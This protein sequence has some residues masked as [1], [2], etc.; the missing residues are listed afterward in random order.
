[1]PKENRERKVRQ[2][3]RPKKSDVFQDIL[4]VG[5]R[6]SW[7]QMPWGTPVILLYFHSWSRLVHSTHVAPVLQ[8]SVTGRLCSTRS[9]GM[10]SR[11]VQL[12]GW[13]TFSNSG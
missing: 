2:K 6:G 1:M 4:C 13:P 9:P 10:H 3:Y 12:I 5:K 11:L 7:F 8:A